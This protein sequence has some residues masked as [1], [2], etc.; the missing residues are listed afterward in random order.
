MRRV[1]TLISATVAVALGVGCGGA[2]KQEGTLGRPVDVNGLRLTVHR[3]VVEVHAPGPR[4][5]LKFQGQNPTTKTIELP[6][7]ELTCSGDDAVIPIDEDVANHPA[8]IEAGDGDYGE[9][10]WPVP[11]CD[12]AVLTAPGPDGDVTWQLRVPALSKT[13]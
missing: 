4:M 5:T 11:A 13:G 2:A 6:A 3:P 1:A 8:E 12:T 10:A 9:L 7:W